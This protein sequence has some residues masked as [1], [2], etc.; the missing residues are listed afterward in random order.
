MLTRSIV[1][2]R[3]VEDHL[4]VESYQNKLNLTKPDTYR[5]DLKRKEAYTAYSNPR[6]FIYQNKDKQS[7]LMRIDELHKFSDGTLN[8]VRTALDDRLKAVAATDDSLEIPK[9]TTVETPMNMSLA[10]KARFESKKEAIHPILTGIGDEIYVTPPKMRVA[11][12]YCTGALLHNITALGG[13]PEWLFDL[14]ALLKSM[15]YAPVSVGTN[16]NDFAG[17]GASFDAEDAKIFDDAYNDRDEGA[18]ANYN[19]LETIILVSPIPSTRIHKDHPKEHIIRKVNSAV[20]TRKMAKQNEAGLISFINTDQRGIIVRNKARLVAQGH[21]QEEGIDYD[22]IFAPIARIEAIRLVDLEFLDRVYKV[23][24]ALYGLHQAPRAWSL[25]TEFEQL[26]LKRFQMSSMRELT[27]FLGLQVEQRKDGIFLS[28]NKYV[29]DILKK[30]G[31]SSVKPDIM[32]ALCACSRF[33]VQPKVSHMHA[34]K[35]IFRYLK[36][37]PTLGLWYPKDSPLELIAYYDNDYAGASLDR[38][39]TTRGWEVKL[40]TDLVVDTQVMKGTYDAKFL[41]T[42][43]LSFYCWIQLYT[44]SIKVTAAR[45][46][47]IGYSRAKETGKELSNLLMASSLPK[48]TLPTQLTSAKVKKVNDE[49]QIR[50]L[51][52]GKRVNI[53]ESSIRRIL[54]LDDAEGT[55]CLTNTKIFEGL[56]R[57]GFVQLIINHQL[58]DMTHHQDIF[59]TSSLTKKVFANMKK[60]KSENTK[61]AKQPIVENLPKVGE[62][63]ALS[64][65]VTSNSVSTPHESK[66]V[67]KDKV[68]APGMFRINPFKNSREENHVPNTVSASARTKPITVSQPPVITKK[69][70]NSDLNGLAFT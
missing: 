67:N 27:F 29:S 1:I 63:N 31:F 11:A 66:G 39:S 62:T 68:I 3:R 44:A 9:H 28:Q 15:N 41:T 35:R 55:S 46:E 14:D 4:G 2:Q 25:S 51:V 47:G 34:V 18:K 13:G 58:G 53:K 33:Q 8:D 12:E 30:F 50:A 56:A 60:D 45:Q 54:R 38:K 20:Q 43:G 7:R 6:G 61:F 24:K 22:E 21:R 19:N 48:T 23:E 10:N 69:D 16:S 65:P 70:V 37:Q 32:F 57:M 17:K 40:Y 42:I 5:F 59:D 26:M 52:D 64:K 49:V 36:G